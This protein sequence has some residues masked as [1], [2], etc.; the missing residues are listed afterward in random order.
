MIKL[1]FVGT[2]Y[3]IFFCLSCYFGY[4]NNGFKYEY[5]SNVLFGSLENDV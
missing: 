5:Y 1:S 4:N 3:F 2:T